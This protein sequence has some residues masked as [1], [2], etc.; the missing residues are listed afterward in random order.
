M[1]RT[2][3]TATVLAAALTATE[4]LADTFEGKVFAYDR[5]AERLVMEDKT[6]YTLSKAETEIPSTLSAGDRVTVDYVS[7]GEDGVGVISKVVIL[8]DAE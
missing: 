7:L 2:L 5:V 6:V 3:I 1:K 4:G 8:E